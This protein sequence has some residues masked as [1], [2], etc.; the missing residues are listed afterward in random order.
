MHLRYGQ[1]SHTEREQHRH[2]GGPATGPQQPSA[3]THSGALCAQRCHAQPRRR[4]CHWRHGGHLAGLCRHG[5]E[6]D[7]LGRR[8]RGY[9][10][11]GPSEHAGKGFVPGLSHLPC[12]P[13]HDQQGHAGGRHP[14]DRG[15][16][17]E[18]GAVLHGD[19]QN[20][21]GQASGGACALRHRDDTRTGALLGHRELLTLFRRT[22]AG[23]TP[24]LPAGFLPRRLP[25]GGGR[26]PRVHTAD[27]CHVR[28]RPGPKEE[29][30][31]IRFP[32]ACRQ[33]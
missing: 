4:A 6:G 8:D 33:G 10:G 2:T 25:A 15:G 23:T 29:P 13:V 16:P 7:L 19:R 27:R 1:P 30:G 3:Q 18:A 24:L 20:L 22:P 5:A 21:R 17:G 9:T 11:T 28:W 14:P 26:K 12:Q 31:G 32:S